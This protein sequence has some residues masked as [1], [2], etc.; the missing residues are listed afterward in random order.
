MTTLTTVATTNPA[1]AQQAEQLLASGQRLKAIELLRPVATTG[2]DMVLAV[3][4]ASLLESV[5]EDEEAISL[6]ERV[7]RMPQPPINALM[8]LAVM[9]EDAADYHRAE[10][11]LRK[12]LETEPAHERARLFLKDVLASRDC[13]YDED[14]ARDDARR[15]QMLDQPVTDFELSVR[16]RNCLK[17]MQ[18]RTLGDLLKITES[19]LLAYKNFG[20]TSLIEIKQMLAGKGLRLGQGL[21]GSG[22]Q[23]VRNEIYEKLKEQVGIEVLEKS[24]ASLEFSVR[25]RKALQ[26]LGIQTLGD[27][28][29][30]T[31]AE[32]M[33]VKN[34]GQTSLDEIRE[35]LTEHG[36]GLR[37]LDA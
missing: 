6:L 33:G 9:Y 15:D 10:R 3:R 4:L 20:E 13:L 16:A 30:R 25:C 18:I 26:M 35:R 12:V 21:E 24:V 36:L 17:K 19:E 37:L 28:A 8:N 2:E 27:L 1:I 31:E 22:Y 34:F 7:C 29:S 11:C 14:Q 23:R 32:L 5:G